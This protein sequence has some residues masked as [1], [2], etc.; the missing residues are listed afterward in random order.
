M[1]HPTTPADEHL[2][3]MAYLR[4]RLSN[5]SELLSTKYRIRSYTQP[6]QTV[7]RGLVYTE[8]DGFWGL[9]WASHGSGVADGFGASHQIQ[10]TAIAHLNEDQLLES[11]INLFLVERDL[12]ARQV[13]FLAKYATAEKHLDNFAERLVGS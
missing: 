4:K 3:N 5:I 6:P 12:K 2:K 13:E 11:C 8:V 9:Y 10:F 1:D 7:L